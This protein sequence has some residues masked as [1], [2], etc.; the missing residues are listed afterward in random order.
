LRTV[1]T[2]A[3]DPLDHLLV[4][5]LNHLFVAW[6]VRTQSGHGTVGSHHLD[7]QLPPSPTGSLWRNQEPH[8]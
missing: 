4:N 6:P 3:C 7:P 2:A 8:R 5:H 1:R